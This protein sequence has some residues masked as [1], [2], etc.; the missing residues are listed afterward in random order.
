MIAWYTIATS[1][2]RGHDHSSG[3]R[4][5]GKKFVVFVGVG[6]VAPKRRRSRVAATTTRSASGISEDQ[7]VLVASVRLQAV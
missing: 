6:M 4:D 1:V 7:N 3:V 2:K 5:I